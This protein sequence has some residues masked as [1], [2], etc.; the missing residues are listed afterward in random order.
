MVEPTDPDEAREQ[1]EVSHQAAG[2]PAKIPS[3]G[4][5][6]ILVVVALFAGV[7]VAKVIVRTPAAR[8]VTGAGSSSIPAQTKKDANPL[9]SAHNDAV[10]DYDAAAKS[11]KPIYVLFHSLS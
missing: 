5:V 4:L 6:I 10:A 8:S 7:L 2:G 11:G 3:L 1:D 9:T